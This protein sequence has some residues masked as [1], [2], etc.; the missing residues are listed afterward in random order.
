MYRPRAKEFQLDR[1][2]VVEKQWSGRICAG[3]WGCMSSTGPLAI[4]EIPPRM[5]SRDYVGILEN[6]MLPTAR[7]R[8][9]VDRY[10]EIVFMQDGS[11]VHTSR[12]TMAW[13]DEHPDIRLI[14]WPSE[15]P[16]LNP[17]EN[18]WS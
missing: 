18:L 13:F 14:N 2:Y 4:C 3:F 7:A 11:A 12:E 16:D 5:N 8:F 10:P 9:P 1:R 17:I 6:V 15:S